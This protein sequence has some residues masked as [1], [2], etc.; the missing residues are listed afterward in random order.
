MADPLTERQAKTLHFVGAFIDKLGYAPTL[1]QIGEYIGAAKP[2]AFET[3][4]RLI[5]GGYITKVD[6]LWRSIKLTDAGQAWYDA[7]D[8]HP[9]VALIIEQHATPS[10]E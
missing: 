1:Q 4:A 2:T 10:V 8:W 7:R 5:K 9:N 6:W 3:I